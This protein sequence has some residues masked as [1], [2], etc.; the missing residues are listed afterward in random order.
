VFGDLE[1]DCARD[2]VLLIY[3][4]LRARADIPVLRS[5]GATRPTAR[6]SIPAD[7]HAHGDLV[8]G[9]LTAPGT[10][11]L[12]SPVGSWTLPT[13]QHKAGALQEARASQSASHCTSRS[14]PRE[15]ATVT[16]VELQLVGRFPLGLRGPVAAPSVDDRTS[17]VK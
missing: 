5:R 3:G 4:L 16:G 10:L 14:A 11:I 2:T 6:V 9:F 15:V 8:C 7:L 1:V 17:S 12:R 13:H